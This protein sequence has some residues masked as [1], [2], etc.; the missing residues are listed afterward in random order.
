[1]KAVLIYC[2]TGNLRAVR[3]LL[4]HSK[5]ESTVRYL[6]IEVVTRSRSQKRSTFDHYRFAEKADFSAQII[7]EI[8]LV[9]KWVSNT[10]TCGRGSARFP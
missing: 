10:S 6:G 2:R 5:I 4:G 9:R 1:M 7:I 3:L 8:W